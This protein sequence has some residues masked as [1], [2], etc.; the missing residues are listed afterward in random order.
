[1]IG[2]GG[3]AGICIVCDAGCINM[4]EIPCQQ[5]R[6]DLF[7]LQAQRVLLIHRRALPVQI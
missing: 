2:T 6:I 5:L 7:L 1:M 3:K 4:T